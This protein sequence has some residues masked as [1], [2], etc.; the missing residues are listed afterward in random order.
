MSDIGTA[1]PRY[2]DHIL[3]AICRGS[4]LGTWAWCLLQRW[5]LSK[6]SWAKVSLLV[7]LWW[8]WLARDL[9]WSRKLKVKVAVRLF[10]AFYWDTSMFFAQGSAAQAEWCLRM[11]QYQISQFKHEG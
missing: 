3:Q 5:D 11:S 8:I 6:G 9:A 7:P 10:V 4:C 2:N 1:E